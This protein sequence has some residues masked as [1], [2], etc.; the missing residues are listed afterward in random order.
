MAAQVEMTAAAVPT[1][2]PADS[3]APSGTGEGVV[4]VTISLT[5]GVTPFG[6]KRAEVMK[7]SLLSFG[8]LKHWAA[9]RA[10][11]GARS[12]VHVCVLAIIA[13]AAPRRAQEDVRLWDEWAHWIGWRNLAASSLS[14]LCAFGAYMLWSVVTASMTVRARVRVSHAVVRACGACVRACAGVC[15]WCGRRGSAASLS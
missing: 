12:L 4:D 2:T 6:T 1:A 9:V 8:K 14:L 13:G 11:C 10:P 15:L 3:A 5:P 7:Q